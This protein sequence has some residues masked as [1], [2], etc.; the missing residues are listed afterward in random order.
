M[1]MP[2][3]Y[4]NNFDLIYIFINLLPLP[5]QTKLLCFTIDLLLSG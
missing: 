4:L 3:L 5:V 2:N 1:H